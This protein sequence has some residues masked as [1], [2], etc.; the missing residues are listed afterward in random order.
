[1][2]TIAGPPV[3]IGINENSSNLDFAIFPNPFSSFVTVKLAYDKPANFSLFDTQGRVVKFLQLN[4]RST[5]IELPELLPGVY[6][7]QIESEGELR[8]QRLIKE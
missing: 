6:L 2:T 5:L 1:M 3:N 8:T 7:M 4:N